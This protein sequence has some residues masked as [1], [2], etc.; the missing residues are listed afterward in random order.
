MA[1]SPTLPQRNLPALPSHPTPQGSPARHRIGFVGHCSRVTDHSGTQRSDVHQYHLQNVQPQTQGPPGGGTLSTA[2]EVGDWVDPSLSLRPA[3][4]HC[5][6][7]T[8]RCPKKSS[9]QAAWAKFPTTN[10]AESFHPQLVPSHSDCLGGLLDERV[11][12]QEDA[13]RNLNECSGPGG[14]NMCTKLGFKTQLCRV[15]ET[16]MRPQRLFSCG[17]RACC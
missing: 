9:C 1:V 8:L 11:C 13:R 15:A 17:L 2:D 16:W 6:T 5:N 10:P 3:S 7:A 14:P 12:F 4:A